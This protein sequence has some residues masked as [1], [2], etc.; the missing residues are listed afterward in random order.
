MNLLVPNSHRR[1]TV[2]GL[3]GCGKSALVLEFAYRALAVQARDVVFWVPAMSEDSF[4][5]AYRQIASHLGLPGADQDIDIKKLVKEALST[6]NF[7]SWLM[8][9]DNADDPAVLSSPVDASSTRLADYLP[10]SHTGAILFTT[11][12][13][14]AAR[15][16][17]PNHVLELK[18]MSQNEAQDLLKQHISEEALFEDAI[19]VDRLLS[20][21][22]YLPLALVQAAA[23]I[24]N[25]GITIS[26]YVSMFEHDG[27]DIE[28][29]SE[30]FEDPSRYREMEST[31]AK[32]WH[33]SFDQI[34]KQDPTA[35]D[36]LSFIA[37]IDRI[38]IPQSLLP[39]G[40]S[41]VQ[42]TRVLGTLTG[43]AFLT[44]RQQT[45]PRQTGLHQERFFDMHRLVHLA[46]TAWLH[47]QNQWEIHMKKTM[48]RLNE[49]VPQG[50]HER[51]DIWSSYLSHALYA[52]AH[53]AETDTAARAALLNRV[54]RCQ[55]DLGQYAAAEV[56]CRQLF[57][58]KKE[59]FGT[60]CEE[61]LTGM[62]PLS[63]ALCNQGKYE[64]A[65]A[66]NRE[67]LAASERVM[68]DEHLH[69]LESM[70]NLAWVL[71]RQG[72][73]VEAEAMERRTLER[74]KRV[75]GHEH[76]LT[77]M[78]LTN[79]AQVLRRQGRYEEAE[80]INR[81]VVVTLQKTLGH[82]HPRTLT[83]ISNLAQVLCRQGK[84]VEAEAMN[85]QE[86]D[87]TQKVL[88]YEHP[89]TLSSMTRLAQILAYQGIYAEAEN[90]S[91]QTLALQQKVL[92]PEYPHTLV[93]MS[94][95]ALMLERQSKHAEAELLFREALAGS[96]KV[97]GPKHPHTLT[98]M[99]NTID[100][101]YEVGKHEEADKMLEQIAEWER[102][103]N[104]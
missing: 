73:Y 25:N 12:S 21:L 14:K 60:E 9:V 93:T 95:L 1:M 17:T 94:D 18:D 51:K 30:Q 98:T 53:K 75:L 8:I 50:G 87:S 39:L 104:S 66:L 7:G 100:L 57:S 11:R 44:E 38:N 74:T 24:N 43:Y 102:N 42:Q 29:F 40:R 23:F 65:E 33:I 91:R 15:A 6:N 90:L 47:T 80:V 88:G 82:E 67:A 97:L 34:Q 69:T 2:Y 96:S 56:T 89:D 41:I 63:G 35:A 22:A 55:T 54:G 10:H 36:C 20:T 83:S 16:L 31:V 81:E 4:E 68:G 61:T 79:L 72:K 103:T 58:L 62:I 49:L 86:L 101:L 46:L 70:S 32:T 78:S 59:M 64:E 45:E 19:S 76:Q 77:L 52:A 3:G 92:G 85:R 26:D 28:L 71:G 27:A 13:R 37:C 5:L 48:Q 99:Y 84:Y